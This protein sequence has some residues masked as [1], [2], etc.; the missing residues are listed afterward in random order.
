MATG[1][2]LS[3]PRPR[4]GSNVS[5]AWLVSPRQVKLMDVSSIGGV[6]ERAVERV[7]LIAELGERVQALTTGRLRFSS[8]SA[9]E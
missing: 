9:V 1:V 4:F 6:R 2:V 7:E 8:I 3:T 5:V